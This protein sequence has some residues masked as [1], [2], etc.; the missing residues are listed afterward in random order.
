MTKYNHLNLLSDSTIEKI[1]YA[2]LFL[3]ICGL[4]VTSS[5]IIDS[6]RKTKRKSRRNKKWKN[7][8]HI[9][10]EICGFA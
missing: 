1:Y 4:N 7:D 3:S 6:N 2:Y 9:L 8:E 10:H 5:N